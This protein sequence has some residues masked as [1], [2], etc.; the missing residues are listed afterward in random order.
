MDVPSDM[1]VPCHEGVIHNLHLELN[2]GT[3]WWSMTVFRN[4]QHMFTGAAVTFGLS[5]KAAHIENVAVI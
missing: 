3:H 1:W 4:G 2:S 5:S